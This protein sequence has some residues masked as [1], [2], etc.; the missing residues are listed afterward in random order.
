MNWF[1]IF[2]P[3]MISHQIKKP[4][5]LALMYNHKFDEIELHE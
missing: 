3:D 5:Y 4:H 2:N 1:N